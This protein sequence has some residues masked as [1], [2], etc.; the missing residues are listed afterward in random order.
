MIKKYV[1]SSISLLMLSVFTNNVDRV[2]RS[3]EAVAPFPLYQP[4]VLDKVR[5]ITSVGW[6]WDYLG[7]L[8]SF[9]F[10]MLAIVLILQ[11][12][13]YHFKLLSG[14]T[15]SHLYVF[16]KMWH[17]V[18]WVIF[19]TSVLD[20]IHYVLAARQFE[21]FFLIQNGIFLIMTAY[22]IYKAYRK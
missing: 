3:N 8:F 21:K 1:I 6:Y 7:D 5:G 19:V 2:F 18:F 13:Y 15:Y 9:A 11:P 20:I 17:R 10:L 4:T 16:T 12:I 22:F 14:N